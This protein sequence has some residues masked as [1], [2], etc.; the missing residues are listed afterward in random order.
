MTE[1]V[2]YARCLDCEAR[3]DGPGSDSE[4]AKHTKK[5]KHSTYSG[6]IPKGSVHLVATLGPAPDDRSDPPTE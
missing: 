2:A 3:W 6:A 4:S 5:E 1:L